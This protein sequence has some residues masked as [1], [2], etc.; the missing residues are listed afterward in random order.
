MEKHR[1]NLSFRKFV[2]GRSL[3]GPTRSDMMNPR[4]TPPKSEEHSPPPPPP[5]STQHQEYDT[6]SAASTSSSSSSLEEENDEKGLSYGMREKRKRSDVLVDRGSSFAAAAG[7]SS[8]VFQDSESEAES[9]KIP[10]RRRSNYH[11][12]SAIDRHHGQIKTNEEM[13]PRRPVPELTPEENAALS[14]MMLSRDKWPDH[15]DNKW[16]KIRRDVKD[17]EDSDDLLNFSEIPRNRW[18][19]I[20]ES[21]N[22]AFKS[23]HALGGHRASHRKTRLV[24][25]S[26]EFH[27]ATGHGNGNRR[28]HK[29]RSTARWASEQSTDSSAEAEIKANVI[30]Y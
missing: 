13:E 22:K 12:R 10:T 15:N 26:N 24:S 18:K 20:C 5:S 11:R 6:E 19:Y 21:C 14:L 30:E 1:C 7:S 2:N 8:L 9:S 4:A 3:G 23:H 28:L 25:E 17:M 27:S 29:R 16:K